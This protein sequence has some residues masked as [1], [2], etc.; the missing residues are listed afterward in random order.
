MREIMLDVIDPLNVK[1]QNATEWW[2]VGWEK[3]NAPYHD[4]FYSKFLKVETADAFCA[5]S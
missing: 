4:L 1:I 3:K 5:H 2:L